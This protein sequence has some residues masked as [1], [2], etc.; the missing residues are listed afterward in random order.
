MEKRGA[1]KGDVAS[2]D[3]QRFTGI[4]LQPKDVI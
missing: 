4:L 2:A 1:F 3:D